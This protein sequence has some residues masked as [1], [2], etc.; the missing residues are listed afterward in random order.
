MTATRHAPQ[1]LDAPTQ[2]DAAPRRPT[3]LVVTVVVL[4]L[5]VVGLII[6]PIGGDDSSASLPD[7]LEQLLDDYTDAWNDYDADAFLA[8]TTSD[9]VMRTER[10][11]ESGQQAQANVI[12]TLGNAEWRTTPVGD[13]IVTGEG[14]WQ[15]AQQTDVSADFLPAGEESGISTFVIVVED[16]VPKVASHTYQSWYFGG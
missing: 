4:L 16:G 1:T 14:P 11:G 2:G 9:Y 8:L 3:A 15:V 6:W 13:P 10:N 5:A 7:D 12:A